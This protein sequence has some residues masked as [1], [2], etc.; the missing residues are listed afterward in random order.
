MVED[1]GNLYRI[2]SLESRIDA[3]IISMAVLQDRLDKSHELVE[4]LK[5]EMSSSRGFFAGMVL[6]CAA[7]FALVGYLITWHG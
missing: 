7:S 5:R 6:A 1:E 4:D 3:L 2:R